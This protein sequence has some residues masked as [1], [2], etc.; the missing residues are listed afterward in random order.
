MGIH[1]GERSTQGTHPRPAGPS[2]STSGT[3]QGQNSSK[4]GSGKAADG[5][6]ARGVQGS[7]PEYSQSLPQSPAEHRASAVPPL[8][9]PLPPQLSSWRGAAQP[10]CTGRRWK[11]RKQLLAAPK[12][13]GVIAGQEHTLASSSFCSALLRVIVL[14]R[15]GSA[16]VLLGN[17]LKVQ[18]CLL[19][20]QC[21]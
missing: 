15:V 14:C 9:A 19:G 20:T 2:M 12:F 6:K 21:V 13:S 3:A 10:P 1:T 8:P 17:P 11:H 5:I 16:S 7:L 18:L 4:A